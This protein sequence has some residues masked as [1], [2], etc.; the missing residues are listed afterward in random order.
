MSDTIAERVKRGA[1]LLDE[2]RPGWAEQI[3]TQYLAM[4]SSCGCVLGRLDGEY[5][6][7]LRKLWPEETKDA[8]RTLA[9]EHGFTCSIDPLGPEWTNLRSAWE[10]EI[11]A[12]RPVEAQS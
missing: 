6:I 4:W 12:R 3:G 11:E 2:K 8:L 5:E 7:G 10:A 1:A 9:G